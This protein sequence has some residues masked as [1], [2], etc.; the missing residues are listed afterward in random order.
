MKNSVKFQQENTRV[1]NKK[2]ILFES[3][4]IT[5]ISLGVALSLE[6]ALA[7]QQ[8]ALANQVI[9]PDDFMLQDT[10]TMPND[11]VLLEKSVKE[12]TNNILLVDSN[13]KI[14]PND[15]SLDKIEQEMDNLTDEVNRIMQTQ[16]K[17]NYKDSYKPEVY[18]G[19]FSNSVL[20]K[21]YTVPFFIKM[22]L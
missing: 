16:K 14:N 2:Q 20:L 13:N 7:Q 10:T 5:T 3:L 18:F 9:L 8:T 4:G 19:Y 6:K 21:L 12:N 22:Y 15:F 17:D 11:S 1:K